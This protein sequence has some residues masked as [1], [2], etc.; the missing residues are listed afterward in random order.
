MSADH[1]LIRSAA[2]NH[3]SWMTARGA[4][5]HDHGALRWIVGEAGEGASLPFPEAVRGRDADAMLADCRAARQSGI[6]CWTTG[7][8]PIGELA[9]V[10]VARGFEWGWSAHWMAFD[11][12]ALPVIDDHRVRVERGPVR[13]SWRAVAPG[14]GQAIVHLADGEAGLYDVGVEPGAQRTGLGRALT[15]AALTAGRR[16]GA[17]IATTN[18]TDEG[19][20]LYRS[21]G[22]R[23]LGRGQTFWIHADG[24][25]APTAP[26][27]VAAAEAAGRGEVPR[28]G[29]DVLGARI[30]GNGMGLAHVALAAGHRDAAARLIEAGA[31]S[32][33]LLVYELAGADGLAGL[34][35]LDAPIGRMGGT[36]LHEAVR[37][38]DSAL[39]HAALA[40]G[41]DREA[42][43][44]TYGATPLEWA[45]YLRNPDA[46]ALL[47]R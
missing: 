8:A 13:D 24:L 27:L 31:P 41:A 20:R 16:A 42:R 22:A 25:A 4:G 29:A 12:D 33:A 5:I 38:R 39:L 21:V 23:S 35:T 32:D 26:A 47:R 44:R 6:G 43:D 30:A 19:E 46:E 45:L 40:A 17:R 15:V 1:A 37:I 11:L 34:A 3:T 36:V 7:L 18:A 28:A 10:L 9:A 14:A 2:R